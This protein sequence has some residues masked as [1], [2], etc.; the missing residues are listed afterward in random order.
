MKLKLLTLLIILSSLLSA[1]AEERQCATTLPDSIFSGYQGR[2]HVQGI[3]VDVAKGVIYFSFTT[4]IVKTDLHGNLLGSVDGLTGHLGCL[5]LNP[6]DGRVYGSIE[7]KD[8][9]IGIGISGED[10]K[11]RESAFY[12]AVFDGDK[13][14]RPDMSPTDDNVMTTVYLADVVDDYNATVDNNGRSDAHRYGCS[15]IDGV[16]FGPL[17]GK[18]EGSQVLYVAY[19]IY[20]DTARTDNDYQVLLAYDTTDWSEYERPLLQDAP[21]HAGP[22]RPLCRFF[23]YTGNTSWGIQNLNYD[24]ATN[25]LLAAVY[26]GIKPG[27]PNFT[28]F[29][30]DLDRPAVYEQLKGFADHTSGYVLPLKKAGIHHPASDTYGWNIVHGATGLCALGD[31]LFYLSEKV[32]KPE[33]SSI[34]RL[35]RWTGDHDDPFQRIHCK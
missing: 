7:Y 6:A 23:V 31:G 26:K 20:A 12:I 34:L 25:S 29:A 19:G 3:A 32:S 9:V 33:Q 16:A 2:H 18:K 21:H 22:A 27:F 5:S 24:P 4:K 11:K 17:P 28:L 1:R 13:I 14:T 30:I 8:D 15:G 35:F 10:A